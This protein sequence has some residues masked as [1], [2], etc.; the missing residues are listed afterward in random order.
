[1]KK[2]LLLLFLIPNLVMAETW[3][4]SYLHNENI[5]SLTFKR[6]GKIFINKTES[7]LHKID[8][9]LY[10]KKYNTS[11][12]EIL[13]ESNFQI[14]LIDSDTSKT[15]LWVL[16]LTKTDQPKFISSHMSYLESPNWQGNCEVIE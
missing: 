7:G 8:P 16:L 12:Y 3:V 2:L 13:Y 5:E 1:M 4:C 15:G 10:P 11:E 9:K 14:K 6:D